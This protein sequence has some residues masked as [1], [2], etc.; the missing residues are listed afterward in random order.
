MTAGI[1][2]VRDE[3]KPT[4][5]TSSNIA[6]AV[7]WRTHLRVAARSTTGATQCASISDL[8]FFAQREIDIDGRQQQGQRRT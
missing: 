2:F 4:E 8:P 1:N 3:W 7:S 5:P 6:I